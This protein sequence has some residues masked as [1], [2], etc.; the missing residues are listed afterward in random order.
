MER[1]IQSLF[2]DLEGKDGAG[3]LGIYVYHGKTGN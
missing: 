3:N 2:D 1:R